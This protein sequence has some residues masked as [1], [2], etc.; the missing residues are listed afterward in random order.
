MVKWMFKKLVLV[1]NKNE[2]INPLE[3]LCDLNS[4]DSLTKLFYQTLYDAAIAYLTKTIRR[5][6]KDGDRWQ[7]LSSDRNHFRA[8]TTSPLVE[9]LRQVSRKSNQWSRMKCDNEIVTVLNK[10]QLARFVDGLET[11][12]G[13]HI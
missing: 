11:F 1:I 4:F 9:H 2:N 8:D 3:R 10:G 12:S 5:S 7:Y 13:R 6:I